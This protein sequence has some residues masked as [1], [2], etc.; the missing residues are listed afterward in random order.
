MNYFNE[1][2]P[3]EIRK[4]TFEL[5]GRDW[6]LVTAKK[7]NKVNTMTASWGGLGILW[8]K[9]VSYVFIRPQRF[10][11]EFVDDSD[12]FSLSFL[13]NKYKKEL[14]YLGSVSG[15]DEDKISKSNLTLEYS[16]NT[17]YFGESNLIIVCKKLYSQDFKPECFI[18]NEIDE[19]NY[20]NKDYH[21]MYIS[22]IKKVLIKETWID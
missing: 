10:T 22:E 19:K 18:E 2:K 14:S 5:I 12:T 15:R 4:N 9:P 6:M 21:T 8:N 20:S 1:I 17:P 16:D 7:D 11:K 3:E 13:A